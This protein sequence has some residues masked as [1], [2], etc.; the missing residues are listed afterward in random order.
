MVAAPLP[1]FRGRWQ[2]APWLALL[3][4]SAWLACGEQAAPEE[5]APPLIDLPRNAASAP[6]PPAA[7]PE[8]VRSLAP[9]REPHAV[10]ELSRARTP[11]LEVG[12][13]PLAERPPFPSS[14]TTLSPSS[15]GLDSRAVLGSGGTIIT[16]GHSGILYKDHPGNLRLLHNVLRDLTKGARGRRILYTSECDPREDAHFCQLA[17]SPDELAGFFAT[18]A[19]FGKL[20]FR[21]APSVKLSD[22]AA[23]IFDSCQG[24]GGVRALD[25][26]LEKGG[27]ALI[28][29]DNFCSSAGLASARN[30]NLVLQGSGLDFSDSDPGATSPYPVPAEQRTGLLEGVESLDIFR[31]APQRI[32]HSFVPVVQAPTGV[33]MARLHAD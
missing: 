1:R 9:V 2:S 11:A 25:S 7:L 23:V 13:A 18:V 16:W 21:W 22:Y 8:P 28:L 10:S 31:V 32:E 19:K 33:L 20:E 5:S 4:S 29:G 26:Y 3:L 24:S 14:W 27:R 12:F 30:A 17:D 15:L 6:E